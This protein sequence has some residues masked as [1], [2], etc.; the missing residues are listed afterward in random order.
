MADA[1]EKAWEGEWNAAAKA[2]VKELDGFCDD[3]N[4]RTDLAAAEAKKYM[5]DFHLHAARKI[6]ECMTTV[7]AQVQAAYERQLAWHAQT[8]A[9]IASRSAS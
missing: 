4:A 5:G 9:G 1:S 6:F 8:A 2:K 7:R 3:E